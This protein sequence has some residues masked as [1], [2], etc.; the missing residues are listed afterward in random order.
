MFMV[1]ALDVDMSLALSFE[2]SEPGPDPGW[3][4]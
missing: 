3:T 2:M 1:D 4:T